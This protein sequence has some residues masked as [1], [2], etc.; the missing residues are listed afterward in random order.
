MHPKVRRN[1]TTTLCWPHSPQSSVVC[2]K[3]TD[4][5]LY[6][7]PT[8]SNTVTLSC[9]CVSRKKLHFQRQPQI[10]QMVRRTQRQ[11]L[12]SIRRELIAAGDRKFLVEIRAS[13][14]SPIRR[15]KRWQ[16]SSVVHRV[17]IET[18]PDEIYTPFLAIL[19]Y[20]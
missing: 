7:I 10:T 2:N 5:C 20:R 4:T 18:P 8:A 3:A 14:G 17:W 9:S 16:A 15:P 1:Q 12:E 13:G 6:L 11:A 19:Y